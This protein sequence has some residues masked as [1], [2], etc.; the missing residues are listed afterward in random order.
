LD[1][2]FEWDHEKAKSNLRKH[3]ISFQRAAAVFLDPFAISL[4]DEEHSR[5]EERWVT[6]GKDNNEVLLVVAHTF[7]KIYSKSCTIR[8]IS[9][10]KA[11]KRERYHYEQ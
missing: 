9:A 5:D 11:T 6:L 3:R 2:N 8:I 1:Y 7:K 10:R 4:F